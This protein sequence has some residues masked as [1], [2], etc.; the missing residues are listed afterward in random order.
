MRAAAAA[1]AVLGVFGVVAASTPARAESE[2][3]GGGWRRHE[4]REHEWQERRRREQEE[5]ERA[6][7]EQERRRY[8]H[9]RRPYAPIGYDAP[10]QGTYA[11][12]P[13]YYPP[14]RFWVPGASVGFSLR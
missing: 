6:E 1:L 9:A 14:P 11:P 13:A 8:E 10:L 3:F 2:E 5:R 4:G 12:V 7:R